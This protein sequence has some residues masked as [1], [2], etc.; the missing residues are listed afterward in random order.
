MA[1]SLGDLVVGAITDD[2]NV[3]GE[4]QTIGLETDPESVCPLKKLVGFVSF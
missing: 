3:L 2:D 1:N 4:L